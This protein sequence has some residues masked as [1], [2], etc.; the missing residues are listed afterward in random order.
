MMCWRHLSRWVPVPRMSLDILGRG[1]GGSLSRGCWGGEA[2]AGWLRRRLSS[3]LYL[4]QFNLSA[5]CTSGDP[6]QPSLP[7]RLQEASRM[8][9]LRH[10]HIVSFF[11][12]SV[13]GTAG[14]ILMEYCEGAPVRWMDGTPGDACGWQAQTG[15]VGGWQV[16]ACGPCPCGVVPVKMRGW[17]RQLLHGWLSLFTF[18]AECQRRH[19]LC[20]GMCR[21]RS[22]C[23]SPDG[24]V[25]PAPPVPLPQC[26]SRP[27]VCA[28]VTSAKRQH[29][30]PLWLVSRG[31][32]LMRAPCMLHCTGLG[33][34]VAPDQCSSCHC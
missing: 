7:A 9:L 21:L 13:D 30:A 3:L 12:V 6:S 4:L 18:K 32:A 11:G 19:C 24:S 26:S 33:P 22:I 1:G 17:G 34:T 25:S 14:L 10:P 8:Q 20:A 5:A 31:A 28:A 29:A 27:V 2:E 16:S 23:L 15:G